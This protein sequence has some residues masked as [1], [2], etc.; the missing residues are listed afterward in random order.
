MESTLRPVPAVKPV[1][2][3]LG[4]KRRLAARIIERLT[5]IPH[6]HYVEPFVGMGG[7]F[8]RRPFFVE[9]EVVNDLNR[10]VANLFRILQRHY[11]PLMDMLR[12][13]I[14]SRD[15]F[16]RLLASN[17]DSL[18]DLERAARFLY[19][20]RTA[21]GGKVNGR[22]FGVSLRRAR[23]DVQELGAAL[24]EVHQRLSRVTI[25]CLPWQQVIKRYD[26]P[27][28]LFYL[29]PPYWGCERDY[30]APFGQEMFGEMA[31]RLARLQGRFV[32]SLNDCP[33]VRQTFAAF[34]IEGIEVGYSVS[35]QRSG[36]GT[37]GE[38]LIS[39]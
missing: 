6:R 30:N 33:E 11:V 28:T 12:W 13:Q 7:V 37:F 14:T 26:R 36:R 19:L 8:L 31:E 2:P 27:E 39:N 24:A 38:V 1:A 29:D 22:T 17:A 20:Q 9:C 32:L 21:F 35:K 34:D 15:E 5:E 18:T 23:F 16:E 3:Y 4:G 25:E 10:D